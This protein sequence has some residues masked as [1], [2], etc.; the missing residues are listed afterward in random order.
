M[1]ITPDILVHGIAMPYYYNIYADK[2]VVACI[3]TMDT[4]HSQ[5]Y[6]DNEKM[7]PFRKEISLLGTI[8]FIEEE[9]NKISPEFNRILPIIDKIID[10]RQRLIDIEGF[11]IQQT[12]F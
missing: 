4:D 6:F 8:S 2:I 7:R 3:T 10:N 9:L 11:A 1:Q 5:L 12:I